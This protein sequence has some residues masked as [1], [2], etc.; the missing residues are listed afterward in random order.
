M[1]KTALFWVFI[2]V[3]NTGFAQNSKPNVVYIMDP[4]CSWCYTFNPIMEKLHAKYKHKVDFTVVTG[5]MIVG[6][7]VRTISEIAEYII[8]G[9]M[10]MQ[11]MTGVTFGKPYFDLVNEGATILSSERPSRAIVAFRTQNS[12]KAIDFSHDLQRLFFQEGFNLNE[13][14]TYLKMAQKFD[15]NGKDFLL[16]MESD[17]VKTST[18]QD[19]KKVEDAGISGFPT[20][21]MRINGKVIL[22]TEGFEQFDKLEKKIEKILKQHNG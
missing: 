1:K 10:D 22:I 17:S 4:M 13:D 21:L 20:L 15:L 7:K 3:L 16:R 14:S 9:H 6:A 8:A 19:F 2:W 5:G 18:L 12:E 11:N